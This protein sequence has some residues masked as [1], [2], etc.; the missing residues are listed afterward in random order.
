MPINLYDF[1]QKCVFT[2]RMSVDLQQ[3]STEKFCNDI[4]VYLFVE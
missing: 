1:F 3:T 2:N 4:N